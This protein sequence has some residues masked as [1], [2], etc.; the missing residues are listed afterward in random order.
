M[1]P[2]AA[3]LDVVGD[4]IADASLRKQR[5]LKA[6]AASVVLRA[7]HVAIVANV[8][9]VGARPRVRHIA[10]EAREA[11]LLGRVPRE[12][13][14]P[15]GGRG[16]KVVQQPRVSRHGWPQR[17][18]ARHATPRQRVAARGALHRVVRVRGDHELLRPLERLLERPDRHHVRVQEDDSLIGGEAPSV[19]LVRR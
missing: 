14:V 19:Q 2:R 7:A 16:T 5:F 1:R 9:E 17:K 18:H 12:R 13:H 15:Q 10:E 3:S 6:L 4:P 11:R 8:E